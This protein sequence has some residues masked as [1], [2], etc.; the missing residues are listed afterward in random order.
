MGRETD[1]HLTLRFSEALRAKLEKAA[2]RNQRSLNTEIVY[3]L[4]QWDALVKR[5][6][7]HGGIL[8][9]ALGQIMGETGKPPTAEHINKISTTL[10]SMDLTKFLAEG[11]EDA[12]TP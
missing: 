3:R 9:F 7:M 5:E 11:E 10:A 6:T 2:R 8:M 1:V 4:E 12:G